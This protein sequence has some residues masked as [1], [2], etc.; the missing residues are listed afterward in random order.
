[1]TFVNSY[2]LIFALNLLCG[3]Q[4]YGA[5]KLRIYGTTFYFFVTDNIFLNPDKEVI[6]EKYDLKGSW[7][8]R[9]STPPQE[10]QRATCSLCNQK[11]VFTK[12]KSAPKTKTKTM[13][14]KSTMSTE[15][16]AEEE[17]K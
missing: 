7:V 13:K 9:N 17:M 5:Y 11:F 3:S 8:K 1:M 15:E 6:N 2:V 12:T 14:K 16:I 10:G 4:I